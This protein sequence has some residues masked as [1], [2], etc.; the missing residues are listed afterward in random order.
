[1]RE[2]DF[3]GGNVLKVEFRDYS[4]ETTNGY[5]R[6]E[7]RLLPIAIP[8]FVSMLRELDRSHHKKVKP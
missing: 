8:R 7:V 2:W 1:M 4:N 3:P 6:V 5:V